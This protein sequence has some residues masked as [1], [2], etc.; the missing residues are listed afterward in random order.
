MKIIKSKMY[1]CIKGE[2]PEEFEAAINAIVEKHPAAEFKIDGLVPYLCHV[3]IRVEKQIPET[4]A[5]EYEARGDVHYC[6]ECP[7]IDRPNKSNPQQK[8]FPC[9]AKIDAGE[10]YPFTRTDSQCC[11]KYYEYEEQK[12]KE[13]RKC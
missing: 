3:W 4:K 2:T 6:L 8:R 12:K 11:D 9:M 13:A 10:D 1:R 5:E 7:Y